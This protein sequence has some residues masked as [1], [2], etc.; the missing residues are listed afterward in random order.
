MSSSR[1]KNPK[2]RT[3]RNEGLNA[4]LLTCQK[5]NGGQHKNSEDKRRKQKQ[6]RELINA[7]SEK[8]E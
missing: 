7:L 1:N 2:P 3:P 4:T 8:E 5:K 6:Q